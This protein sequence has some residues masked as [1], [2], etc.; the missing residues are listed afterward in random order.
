MQQQLETLQQQMQVVEQFEKL[1]NVE[2]P[3]KLEEIL[4]TKE[5]EGTFL[6]FM[7]IGAE[8]KCK[9]AFSSPTTTSSTPTADNLSEAILH[10]KQFLTLS[11]PQETGMLA[12]I[13]GTEDPNAATFQILDTPNNPKRNGT[14]LNNV[15][16]AMRAISKY[17]DG[18]NECNAIQSLV[19]ATKNLIAKQKKAV[20]LA[21]AGENEALITAKK[22][23]SAE[24]ITRFMR[25]HTT[26]SKVNKE[27]AA[28]MRELSDYKKAKAIPEGLSAL[29]AKKQFRKKCARYT[30]AAV[31]ATGGTA[32][33]AFSTLMQFGPQFAM[34]ASLNLPPVA[35]AAVAVSGVAMVAAAAYVAYRTYKPAPVVMSDAPETSVIA[36][37][38]IA[39]NYSKFL[40]HVLAT[41]GTGMVGFSALMQF[42]PKVALLMG[43]HLTPAALMSVAAVGVLLI[44][45]S[46]YLA[47]KAYAK[48]R[49]VATEVTASADAPVNTSYMQR[50]SQ[51]SDCCL[52]LFKKPTTTSVATAQ[53]NQVGGAPTNMV[54]DRL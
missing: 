7:K 45:A 5:T 30:G 28:A 42:S 10:L 46:L 8:N 11:K 21:I 54:M 24:K 29:E 16:S 32:A 4:G 23:V 13:F 52:K 39:T 26:P 15:I 3:S 9:L 12:T 31:L 37:P 44:S 34:L 43:L 1:F 27:V 2:N 51:H 17:K 18:S 19:S 53:G 20:K 35:L 38:A 49:V 33:I 36:S 48:S 22:L 6:H 41:M 25:H 47:C 14:F 40:P 50:L